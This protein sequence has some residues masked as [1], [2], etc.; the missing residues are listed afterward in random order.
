MCGTYNIYTYI[1]FFKTYIYVYKLLNNTNIRTGSDMDFFKCRLEF[2]IFL[3]LCQSCSI[4]LH[5]AETNFVTMYIL[6][7]DVYIT[8]DLFQSFIA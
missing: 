3:K 7:Y 1:T 8:S 6:L 5:F 4:L 2:R